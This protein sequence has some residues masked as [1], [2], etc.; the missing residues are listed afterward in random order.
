MLFPKVKS[1]D[2]TNSRNQESMHSKTRCSFHVRGHI[3]VSQCEILSLTLTCPRGANDV[4]LSTVHKYSLGSSLLIYI[5]TTIATSGNE[6]NK[7]YKSIIKTSIPHYHHLTMH[8]F[9]LPT[10][11]SGLVLTSAMPLILQN[12]HGISPHLAPSQSPEFCSAPPQNPSV[13]WCLYPGFTQSCQTRIFEPQ[14]W[15]VNFPAYDSRPRSIG[16]DM[17]KFFFT[18]SVRTCA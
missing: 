1:N 7:D 18:Y 13:K 14:P 4:W 16:P 17:G 8:F 5:N 12:H 15:C 9:T 3:K 2:N 10:L 11:L 6:A